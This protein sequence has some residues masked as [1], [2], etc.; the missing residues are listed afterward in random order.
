[1]RFGAS[2]F[3]KQSC[4]WDHWRHFQGVVTTLVWETSQY[5]G[6]CSTKAGF[7]GKWSFFRTIEDNFW[8]SSRH[9]FGRPQNTRDRAAQ[10]REFSGKWSFFRTIEDNFWGSSRHSCGRP[11]NSRDRAA[12]KR[13]FSGKWFFFRTVEDNFLV[14]SSPNLCRHQ[15]TRDRPDIALENSEKITLRDP[16]VVFPGREMGS[17]KTDHFPEFSR[18]IPGRSRVIWV[19]IKKGEMSLLLFL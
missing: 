1:M 3:W 4:F 19:F 16:L 9:S 13:E 8:G 11:Q 17:W 7:F 2:L 5:P 6:S 15:N 10:K 18:G 14:L 12:Q